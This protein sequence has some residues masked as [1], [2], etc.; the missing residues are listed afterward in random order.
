[1]SLQDVAVW[2]L[3]GTDWR[4]PTLG[5]FAFLE[6][7]NGVYHPG[8]DLNSLYGGWGTGCN[9]DQGAAVVAPED[10]II[11]WRGYSVTI[12]G[13]GFG[14]H[15]WAE[16]QQ[17]GRW[18]HF[19][20]LDGQPSLPIGTFAPRGTGLGLC[21]RTAGWECAHLHFEATFTAP[22]NDQW[23]YWP[24]GWGKAM[25]AAFYQDPYAYLLSVSQPAPGPIPIPPLPED[26]EEPM[27]E[28]LLTDA[29]LAHKLMPEVWGAYYPGDGGVGHAIPTRWRQE[30]RAGRDLGPP[31]DHEQDVPDVPDAKYQQFQR[32]VLVFRDGKTSLVG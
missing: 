10:L 8:V 5:G 14:H 4:H 30:L 26:P 22:P 29:E 32:G 3:A 24:M 25:V 17:S 13:R 28:P 7:I 27:D 9:V 20:H 15:T 12:S 6:W 11:R 18:L 31:L 23:D 21:G 16:G 2:P 1:V 19:C